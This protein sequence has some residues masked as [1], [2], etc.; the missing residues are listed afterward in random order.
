MRKFNFAVL[1]SNMFIAAT[2]VS[3]STYSKVVGLAASLCWLIIAM[4]FID[5]GNV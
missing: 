5:K 2:L 4:I 3:S 1:I